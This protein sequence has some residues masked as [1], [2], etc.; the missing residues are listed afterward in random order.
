[1]KRF[2]SIVFLSGFIC[3]L[4]FSQSISNFDATISNYRLSFATIME[5]DANIIRNMIDSDEDWSYMQRAILNLNLI[6]ITNDLKTLDSAVKNLEKAKKT[7]AIMDPKGG[8]MLYKVY[9]GMSEAF[10]AQKK[11]IFG[12]K[13]LKNAEL[14]FTSMPADFSD[15]YIR[16]LRGVSYYS[17]G[18]SLPKIEPL[19]E[20]KNKAI[21]LGKNDLKYVIDI[22]KTKR[23]DTFNSANYNWQD[24][25]IPDNVA[26]FAKDLLR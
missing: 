24:I 25:P 12:G 6:I 19:K 7:N 23:L 16:Y 20:A 10:L 15:W 4:G 8:L 1:M 2:I 13:N 9:K 5:N 18:I 14:F 21:A 22:H 3:F 11:T 17:L 26:S